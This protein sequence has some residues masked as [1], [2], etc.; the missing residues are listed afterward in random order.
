MSLE[1]RAILVV[2]DGL[3]DRV[4]KDGK[5][6]LQLADK[7]IL[8]KLAREGS[9]GLMSTLGRGIIPGSDT[10]H[11][12]LFGYEPDLYYKGRGPFEALGVGVKL[13][14]GDVAFRC[15]FATVDE[16]LR[17]ID[18]RAG[19]LKDEGTELAKS[20]QGMNIGGIE[21]IF[22]SSTEHRGTLILRGDHLSPNVSDTDPH[23]AEPA[24][25]LESKPV[26]NTK[27]AKK[28]AQ[29]L[30]EVIRESKAILSSHPLNEQ[31]KKEGKLPANIVLTRGAGAYEKVE[32]LK[33][34]YGFSSCCIAGSA[35][36]KGVAKYVG[37][38]IIEPEGATGRLDTDIEAK[39]RAAREALKRFHLVFIHVKG[40][41][42]ASHDGNL[43]GKLSMIKKIDRLAEILKEEDAY[44]TITADHSTPISIRRHSSDPVPVLIYGDSVRKDKVQSFDEISV[45]CGC[46]GH[47]TGVE[48]NRVIV[49]LMGY[50]HMIGS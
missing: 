46:L 3:G 8:D 48:L 17:V 42:N 6:P 15:N 27:E 28:T 34:K 9:T 2:V 32:S 4:V 39:A 45:S 30:N 11:L 22:L 12:A 26:K 5:T 21:V 37:M 16:N 1:K 13:R 23:S 10:A 31:R 38:E 25:V 43:E 36:Y 14:Q 18:R 50:G 7:P 41:D 40:A 49:D 19:R 33:D 20:L 47:L 24:A 35:L 44:L 29:I